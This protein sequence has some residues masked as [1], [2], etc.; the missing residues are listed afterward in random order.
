MNKIGFSIKW[1]AVIFLSAILLCI[2]TAMVMLYTYTLLNQAEERAINLSH[3]D[4]LAISELLNNSHQ[5]LQQVALLIPNMSN[6]NQALT[7]QSETDLEAVLQNHWQT[8]S[9][10]LDIHYLHLFDA[11]GKD[12]GG[13]HTEYQ[14]KQQQ[15]DLITEQVIKAVADEQPADFLLC[16][17]QC[18]LFVIE[19]FILNDDSQGV[20]AIGQSISNLVTRFKLLTGRNLA[21][22]KPGLDINNDRNLPAWD[23][24]IWALNQFENLKPLL[25]QSMAL[26]PEPG[27]IRLKSKSGTPYRIQRIT[28]TRQNWLG[29]PPVILSLTDIT[30]EEQ[31]L[32]GAINNGI[33]SGISGL[34]LSE[35]LLLLLIWR[36][37]QRLHR[38]ATTLPLLSEYNFNAVRNKISIP[39]NNL[40]RDELDLVE[41]TVLQVSDEFEVLQHKVQQNAEQ[42]EQQMTEQIRARQFMAQ[43]L[44]T[45]PLIIVTQ[46]SNGQIHTMNHWGRKMTRWV[47]REQDQRDH[48]SFFS[49]HKENSLPEDYPDK[50][51]LLIRR[52]LSVFQHEAQLHDRYGTL[53][54]ITWMHS[55]IENESGDQSILSVGMDLTDRMEAEHKLSWLASHD[56]LTGLNN[57]RA[58]QDHLNQAL[59]KGWCGALL[60]I[61]VDRFKSINDTAG[62]GVG[63]QVLRKIAR[64]LQKKTRGTDFVARLGGDE[65]TIS[66]PRLDKNE[67]KMVMAK[68]SE[69]L[70]TQVSLNNGGNQHFSCSIGCAMYPE[71]GSSDEELLASA[72]IAMYNAKQSGQG[73]WHQYDSTEAIIHR[74]QSDVSWQDK[75]RLAFNDNL[76]RLYF[77]PILN[78]NTRRICHYEVLLRMQMPNGEIVLPGDFIPVA[79]R[80]G[81]IWSIDKWVLSQTMEYLAQYN[82]AC[83]DQPIS[84]AVNI[85]APTIQSPDFISL[86]LS[87]CASHHIQPEQLIIEITETA[88]LEDFE[89]AQNI[90]RTLA[91]HGCKIALDDFGVGFSSFSYLKQMPLTYVKLDGS[92]IREIVDS[93][94]EQTFVRCL[95]EMVKGFDMLTIAEFVE[96][97]AIMETLQQLGVRY[98]QGYLIGKPT[99]EIED[100]AT[101]TARL[102]GKQPENQNPQA[103]ITGEKTS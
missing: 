86:F 70:N 43:L 40:L 16:D 73:R 82:N 6:I 74:I 7:K 24:S 42:L 12:Q 44:D 71:H 64:I 84:L 39:E 66:L 3:Q 1:K 59:N 101:I 41:H 97:P 47:H 36:P 55:L 17:T 33:L 87:L 76:F 51:Q 103:L 31:D 4:D 26:L 89:S 81:L 102:K 5:Q 67:A 62:H 80:T 27:N 49:L 57:R 52:E 91:E 88:F 77:Q 69:H 19:P 15:I 100:Q 38:L 34:V 46:A 75:I 72:D 14:I 35:L 98:A 18:T 99:P 61:D 11:T 58:F 63:D 92:Y 45:A 50:V 94:Q 9:L 48:D 30:R 90:L 2:C 20:I 83:P 68:L 93:P 32:Y 96:T 60:F 29:S 13:Y 21:I 79:E 95:T 85:S 53:R 65:F 10:N 37:T 78:I 23:M 25:K 28:E 54:Y 8:L 56:T 22:I